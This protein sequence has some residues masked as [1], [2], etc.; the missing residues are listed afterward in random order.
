MST[1]LSIDGNH[2]VIF[3]HNDFNRKAIIASGTFENLE[4]EIRKR[5]FKHVLVEGGDKKGR[6]LATKIMKILEE[7]KK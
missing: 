1:S 2:I 5:S 3:N 4:P 7:K 6:E